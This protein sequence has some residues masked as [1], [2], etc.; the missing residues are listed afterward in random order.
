MV[1]NV[2]PKIMDVRRGIITP[3]YGKA[4]TAWKLYRETR[5]LRDKRR[6]KKYYS[7]GLKEA[8]ERE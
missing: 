4:A 5:D 3:A 1:P 7:F 6:D 2:L 8:G